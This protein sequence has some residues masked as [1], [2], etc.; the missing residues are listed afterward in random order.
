MLKFKRILVPVSGSPSDRDAVALACNVAKASKGKIYVAYVIEVK[1]ELP[2]DAEIDKEVGQGERILDE[3]ERFA[4]EI[5]CT[6]ETDLLQAREAGPALVDEAIERN[7][8]LIIIGVPYRK[9]FGE[10]YWGRVP[11]YILRNAP[12]QVWICR[13]AIS[14]G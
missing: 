12:C 1:R 4:E 6:I 3:A 2:L 8:D 13:E 7:V 9:R 5:P 10:F 11:P 14:A